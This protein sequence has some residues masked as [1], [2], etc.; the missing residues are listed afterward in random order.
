MLT[1]TQTTEIYE[2]MQREYGIYLCILFK[3]WDD[4]MARGRSKNGEAKSVNGNGANLGS[5][6]L[7]LFV[8]RK[9]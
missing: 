7:S 5:L 3:R 9:Y 8:A 4:W 1:V 2:T 6:K